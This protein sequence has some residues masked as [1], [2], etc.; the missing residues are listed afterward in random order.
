MAKYLSLRLRLPSTY[1]INSYPNQKWADQSLK[2]KVLSELAC[3]NKSESSSLQ[4]PQALDAQRTF[5][6]N[7]QRQKTR[8]YLSAGR[9]ELKGK[10]SMVKWSQR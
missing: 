1:L 10:Q 4:I 6:D 7:K 5:E 8:L 9:Q 2:A 3:M